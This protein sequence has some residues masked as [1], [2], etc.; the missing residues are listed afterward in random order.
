VPNF[1]TLTGTNGTGGESQ[2]CLSDITLDGNAPNVGAG[3]WTMRV[4]AFNYRVHRVIFA[5]STA[6][7]VYSEWSTG[8][9][10]IPM[11]ASWSDFKITNN[12]GTGL[13][14]NGPHDSMF[15]QGIVISDAAPNYGTYGIRDRGNGGGEVFNAV[16]VWGFHQYG[17]ELSHS[18]LAVACQAEGASIANIR[19]LS[20]NIRWQGRIFGTSDYHTGEV[21]V[22]IGDATLSTNLQL[23]TIDANFFGFG[24]TSHAI[25]FASSGGN[26]KITGMFQAGTATALSIGTMSPADYIDVP[27]QD[28]PSLSLVNFGHPV[29]VNG[30]LTINQQGTAV[31]S[32]S[33]TAYQANFLHGALLRGWTGLTNSTQTYELNASSGSLRLGTGAGMGARLWSGSGVPT[34]P[35]GAITYNL[36][37][38][39]LRTDTPSTA[40]QRLY[41]VT[42]AGTSPAWTGIL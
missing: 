13:D 19:C 23:V 22:Q 5:G 42:T 39:Y 12:R 15:S 9:G 27:C 32:T 36:G 4:Y 41:V 26:N 17:W 10:A 6:G 34:T 30:A 40:N 25:N 3:L 1:S 8:G 29:T 14:W 20:Q 18:C 28:V 2:W 33:S 37:D 11:E 38:A 24:P 31:F 16:H 21:G 7:G 35:G